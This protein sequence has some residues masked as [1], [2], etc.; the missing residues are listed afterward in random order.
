MLDIN[1]IKQIEFTMPDNIM[2]VI[3]KK[4]RVID[5]INTDKIKVKTTLAMFTKKLEKLNRHKGL[6]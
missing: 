6:I 2:T 3:L 1:E 4:E 5:G